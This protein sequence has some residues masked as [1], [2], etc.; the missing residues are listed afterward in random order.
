MLNARSL[1]SLKLR[2]ERYLETLTPR[3]RRVILLISATQALI[4][5]IEIIAVALLGVLAAIGVS[6]ISSSPNQGKIPDLLGLLRINNLSFQIQALLIGFTSVALMITKT[7]F[8]LYLTKRTLRFLSRKSSELSAKLSTKLFDTNLEVILSKSSHERA[9]ALTNGV[10]NL[11]LGV[12]GASILLFS[13]FALL[14]IM[15]IGLFV[16][17]PTMAFSAIMIF[18]SIGLVMYL[19]TNQR[20]KKLGDKNARLNILTNRKINELIR[21]YRDVNIRSSKDKF[22]GEI[23]DI[24]KA[25]NFAAAELSLIP[26]LGKYVLE[27]SVVI[28]ALLIGTLQFYLHDTYKAAISISIFIAAGS[29]IA[30]AVLRLQQGMVQVKSNIGSAETT[31]NLIDELETISVEIDGEI[32]L[33]SPFTSSLAVINLSFVYRNS[34]DAAVAD[35]SLRVNP[36][37]MVAIVGPSGAGKSTLVDLILGNLSPSR[38]EILLSGV[39]PKNAL[40]LWPGRIA[41]VPQN[42]NVIEGTLRE[43]VVLGFE[44]KNEDT[45]LMAALKDAQLT[46]FVQSLPNGVDSNLAE[47]GAS[48]SG[49]QKQRLGIA[50]ALFTRPDFILLDEATSALDGETEWNVTN[51]LIENR[52]GVTLVVIAHRLTT[53]MSADVIFYM[54][55]G[56]ILASGKFEELRS[57]L[58]DF[59]LQAQRMGL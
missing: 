58:P 57:L 48:L 55:K 14:V 17:D 4:S 7:L 46:E 41:Y 26:Y 23:V 38:G 52:E 22:V 15:S 25:Q 27:T 19:A 49:G 28:S 34:T 44:S 20:A 8:S 32:E 54:D 1:N 24:R 21:I 13:D 9:Y 45:E 29:R 10:S 47:F 56:R 18:A 6:G 16:V 36:G 43:N 5:I 12:I 50:R 11:M 33:G 40:R 53:I 51:T 3:E 37:E 39:T 35:I 42:I 30:P 2:I 59:E 31:L